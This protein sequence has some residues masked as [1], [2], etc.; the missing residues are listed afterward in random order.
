MGTNTMV[1]KRHPS[2]S[3]FT[4]SSTALYG[5]AAL[6]LPTLPMLYSATFNLP[7]GYGGEENHYS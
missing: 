5:P 3:L 7:S 2:F 4:L 6:L 1:V